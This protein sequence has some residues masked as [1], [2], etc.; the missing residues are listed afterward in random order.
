LID[1]STLPEADWR[2]VAAQQAAHSDAQPIRSA[3]RLPSGDVVGMSDRILVDA[4]CDTPFDDSELQRVARDHG[5]AV[6]A[7]FPWGCGLSITFPSGTTEEILGLCEALRAQ[8]GVVGAHPDFVRTPRIHATTNDPLLAD[9]WHLGPTVLKKRSDGHGGISAFDAWDTTMGSPETLIA[10][11]DDGFETTHPDLAA[12]F[13]PGFDY[14]TGVPDPTG[15]PLYDVHGTAVAGIVAA[16]GENSVGV[17]GVC[18]HCSIFPLR[19]ANTEFGF[20]NSF[21][22][23]GQQGACAIN[24]SWGITFPTQTMVNAV[25]NLSKNGR[26]GLGTVVVFAAGNDALDVSKSGELTKVPG[27]VVVSA[28]TRWGALSD[29]SNFGSI[30][31]VTAPVDGTKSI[32]TTDRF[33]SFGYVKGSY[34]DDFNGTSAAAPMVSGVL[35]LVCS[36]D[37]S[38]SADDLKQILVSSTDKIGEDYD[39]NGHSP[40]FGFGRINAA[41][42]VALAKT[43]KEDAESKLQCPEWF[44]CQSL[45]T[46]V[47]CQSDCDANT[48]APALAAGEA[49]RSCLEAEACYETCTVKAMQTCAA[50]KCGAELEACFETIQKAHKS[51]YGEPTATD[52]EVKCKSGDCDTSDTAEP[53]KFAEDTAPALTD[54][55]SA[56]ATATAEF[57]PHD[58]TDTPVD[59]DSSSPTDEGCR[60]GDSPPLPFPIVAI[61]AL[62][63]V[64]R[65][66]APYH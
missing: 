12:N 23:A 1:G 47:S 25:A 37:A 64:S 24:N 45:C 15:I 29:Y 28:S 49:A 2:A 50:L 21:F 14:A 54:D 20:S 52:C 55:D 40:K 58:S 66:R 4:P 17:A 48:H 9:Q 62:V 3:L 19:F 51:G 6:E 22:A 16:V 26:G 32:L 31:T 5:A 35:G 18:P 42:A 27:V 61:L 39:S 8:P 10:V 56:E 65:S 36:V 11:L 46:S 7:P 43:W 38:L 13:I 44:E 63:A 34:F 60:P 57:D 59:D 41:K 53:D 30:I 33:G